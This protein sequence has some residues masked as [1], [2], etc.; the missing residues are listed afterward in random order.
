MNEIV[1]PVC[2]LKA[3]LPGL[4][5]IVSKRSTLPVLQTVRVARDAAGRVSLLGTDLD[6]FAT[7]TLKE[8]QPGP[9]VEIL[10]PLDQLTKAVKGLKAEGTLDLVPQGSE[11]V[12]LRYTI[13]DNPVEQNVNTLPA[14]EF[15]PVPKINQPA[16]PLE[17]GFGLALRQ[18]LA[19]CSEESS[20]Y[21][22]K[23]ACL[24]V[25][26]NKLH[27]IVGTNGRCLFAANSFCF[28]LKQPVVVPNSK[29]LEWP[30]LMG[31]EPA[32][33]SV[34]PGQKAEPAKNGKPAKE[35]T[36]GWVKLESGCWTFITKE[37]CGE[38]PNW[39]QVIPRTDG[40][41]TRVD[42]SDAALK[43][44]LL[45]APNLPGDDGLN[46]PVRLRITA[47]RLHL[48]GR[49]KDDEDWTSIPVDAAV[50]GKPVTVAL[51]RRYLLNALRFGLSQI[52]IE[53]PLSPVVFSKGGK[54]LIIM[55]VNLEGPG[56]SVRPAPAK[57]EP[58]TVTTPVVEQTTSPAQA[59]AITEERKDMNASTMTA[60]ERGNLS[61]TTQGSGQGEDTR[62]AFRAALE[63]IDEI[64][65]HLRDVI[66][67]LTD[68]ANLLKTAE[69]EQK[70]TTR[71][72]QAVRAKLREIQSVAI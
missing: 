29:F 6:A 23:G 59:G 40:Q 49:N 60:P 7:Y 28:D 9:A 58:A 25:R 33:L 20:R 27:Y 30:E 38:F 24:D 22:L 3:A 62:S 36:A 12:K 65:A 13:G 54:K 61:N 52:E 18:A 31:Q 48:E 50:T 63:Q 43:Q 19:C 51:N 32:S 56:Q 15:P 37:I 14:S 16:I 44:L 41:W 46:H 17:P 70:T 68:A 39:K 69:K 10:I 47:D 1:I 64:K 11:K 55:P 67:D 45:V 42:L 53:A 35:A 57:S 5:K 72:M 34:E 26:E 4:N 66:G 71:E 2:D 8:A 21:I